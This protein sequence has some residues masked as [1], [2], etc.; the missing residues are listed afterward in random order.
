MFLFSPHYLGYIFHPA[1]QLK[2]LPFRLYKPLD[3]KI[4]GNGDWESSLYLIPEKQ[5]KALPIR[6]VTYIYIYTHMQ[7]HICTHIYIHICIHICTCTHT[8]THPPYNHLLMEE[9]NIYWV[10]PMHWALHLAWF[11]HIINI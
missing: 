9:G 7:I 4:P 6:Y 3:K 8:Q 11:T 1:T 10:Y 2:L 5:L